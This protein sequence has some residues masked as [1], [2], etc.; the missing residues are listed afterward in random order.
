MEEDSEQW[1]LFDIGDT[2]IRPLLATIQI[3]PLLL[4]V[5]ITE[6]SLEL[7]L[8]HNT[9]GERVLYDCVEAKHK[10]MKDLDL[11]SKQ[12]LGERSQNED[13]EVEKED[14]VD[15]GEGDGGD[16]DIVDLGEGH[17]G[18]QNLGAEGEGEGEE[19]ILRN[20]GEG[21]GWETNQANDNLQPAASTRVECGLHG[22]VT[23]QANDDPQLATSIRAENGLHG[24]VTNQA[25]DD[26]QPAATN[27]VDMGEPRNVHGSKK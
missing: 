8:M 20:M 1:C 18:E 6:V 17:G 7:P 24:N 2:W 5:C 26:R 11:F 19:P 25:N 13:D 3:L 22:N 12:Q 4:W 15:L 27:K 9:Y 10:S 14:I 21:E 23:N 16:D